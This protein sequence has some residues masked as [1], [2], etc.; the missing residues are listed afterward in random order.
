MM[1]CTNDLLNVK[2]IRFQIIYH[3]NNPKII[4]YEKMEIVENQ[5]RLTTKIW[6]M[7]FSRV[8]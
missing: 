8:Q 2:Q 5:N 4:P 3:P 1:T 7:N 6:F